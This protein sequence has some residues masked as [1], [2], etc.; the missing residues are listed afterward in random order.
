MN[1][2]GGLQISLLLLALTAIPAQA[3]AA[4]PGFIKDCEAGIDQ[5]T[6]EKLFAVI[7]QNA[8]AQSQCRFE[9]VTTQ[10]QVLEIRWS[11]GGQNQT[12]IRVETAECLTS[13]PPGDQAFVVD[14]PGELLSRCPDWKPLVEKLQAAVN[15]ESPVSFHKHT[16]PRWR[17][18]V[19]IALVVAAA[20]AVILLRRMRGDEAPG[21]G[22]AA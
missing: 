6:T 18:H 22:P 7:S 9:G 4:E 14:V 16:T 2:R 19:L 11:I 8:P 1:E 3:I 13:P 5:K 17:K 20:L 12:P 15:R 21:G 10:K